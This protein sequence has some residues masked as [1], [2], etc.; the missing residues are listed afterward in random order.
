MSQQPPKDPDAITSDFFQHIKIQHAPFNRMDLEAELL[1]SSTST[2]ALVSFTGIVREFDDNNTQDS[3]VSLFLEHYP[4]MT[5]KILSRIVY[6][7]RQRW[8]IQGVV[9]IHRIGE[10]ACQ[11]PIVFVGVASKHRQAA[12]ES[13]EFIMDF[14]KTQAPFWKKENRTEGQGWVQAKE[15]DSSQQQRWSQTTKTLS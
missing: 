2:G 9:L 11:E 12:F 7:A 5:E 3:L 1:S 6:Q 15:E 8:P 13:C 4:G 14:L 10:L